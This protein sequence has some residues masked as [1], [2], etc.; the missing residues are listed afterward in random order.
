MV[1]AF[2]AVGR[3][4][5][6]EGAGWGRRRER[7]EPRGACIGA[8]GQRSA[9]GSSLARTEGE[10]GAGENVNGLLKR[11]PSGEIEHKGEDALNYLESERPES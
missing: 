2:A 6:G 9:T 7:E 1:T 3:R 5:E 10:S 4:E 8:A 11:G